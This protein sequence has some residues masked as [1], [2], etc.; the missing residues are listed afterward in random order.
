MR[1]LLLPAS[2]PPVLGGLQTVAH[3]LA[4][5][6]HES[7]HDVRVFT[8]RYPRSLPAREFLEGI[9]IERALFLF[10]RLRQIR[11]LRFDL[12]LAALYYA[13]KT[14]GRL[15][16]SIRGFRPDVVNVHFPGALANRVVWLRRRFDFRLVV[17]LHGEEVCRCQES[18]ETKHETPGRAFEPANYAFQDSECAQ[19]RSILRAADSVTACSAYLLDRAACLDPCVTP[20]GHVIHNGISLDRFS[21]DAR[22]DHAFPYLFAYGRLT[23]IKGF[24]LLIRAFAQIA[25]DYPEICIVLAGEGEERESLERLARSLGLWGRILFYGLAT[26]REIVGLLN[27]CEFVVVPSR[28]ETFGIVALE[29]MAAGKPLLTTGVG[30]IREFVKGSG[31]KEIEPTVDSLA[32]GLRAWLGQK[33]ELKVLGNSNRELAHPYTWDNVVLRY[34]DVYGNSDL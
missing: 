22:F 19:L 25:D 15:E 20:K 18:G 16:R 6:L 13:P 7:G 12:F 24:D 29:A 28:R 1:I 5:Q 23:Y 17:S 4:T 10:P 31:S 34:L 26:P 2:Y 11:S 27:G 30:G 32:C 33:E 14:V 9:S 3:C 21:S 8:N